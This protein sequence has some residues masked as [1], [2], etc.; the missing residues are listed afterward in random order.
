MASGHILTDVDFVYSGFGTD[1]LKPMKMF[2]VRE[3]KALIPALGEGSMKPKVLACANFIESVGD[4]RSKKVEC[5][6]GNINKAVDVLNGKSGTNI[7]RGKNWGKRS[8]T[9]STMMDLKTWLSEQGLSVRELAVQLEVAPKTVQDWVYE[10]GRPSRVNAE[11]LIVFIANNCAHHWVIAAP[12]GPTS[13]GVCQ[14][15]GHQKEFVNSAESTSIWLKGSWTI[16][17]KAQ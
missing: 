3:S 7:K 11:R 15:C 16:R 2:S 14:R 17:P 12:N 13:E 6:I 8:S 1:N 10:R 9:M 5:F 4:D